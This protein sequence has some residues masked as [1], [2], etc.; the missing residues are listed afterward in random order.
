VQTSASLHCKLQVAPQVPEGQA[1]TP[2][3][4]HYLPSSLHCCKLQVSPQVSP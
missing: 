1:Q 3:S 2:A 4:L